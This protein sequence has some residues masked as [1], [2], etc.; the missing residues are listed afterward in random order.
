MNSTSGIYKITCIPNQK[1]YVGQSSDLTRR[2][3][4]HRRKLRNGNH[5]NVYLQSAFYYYGSENIKIEI[6]ENLE[7]DSQILFEREKY[8]IEFFQ[9]TNRE[10]GFNL[11]EG[12][13]HAPISN[14][15]KEKIRNSLKGRMPTEVNIEARIAGAKKPCSEEKKRKIGDSN[16]GK[17]HSPEVAVKRLEARIA[18]GT[19]TAWNKGKKTGPLSDEAKANFAAKIKET[20]RLKREAKESL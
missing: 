8:W 6:I 11:R 20:L 14:E 1:V 13:F 3:K 15:Q 17:K 7:K 10:K 18:N 12:G 4:D 19:N 5:D 16:K 2:I 9:S